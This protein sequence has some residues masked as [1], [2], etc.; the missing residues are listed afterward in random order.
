MSS[1][2]SYV[3]LS[4][5]GKFKEFS[6]EVEES[7]L[8][9]GL[10]AAYAFGAQGDYGLPRRFAPRN[11]TLFGTSSADF[12]RAFVRPALRSPA[13][14]TTIWRTMCQ[15]YCRGGHVRPV[16]LQSKIT[17]PQAITH[18]F[19]RKIRKWNIWGRVADSRPLQGDLILQ[20]QMYGFIDR[21]RCPP[22]FTAGIDAIIMIRNE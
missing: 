14:Q 3:I 6:C 8:F 16:I 5:A 7:V 22:G 13:R 1:R 21:M 10:W 9:C 18:I 19:L 20:P 12:G 15:L 11:D 4:E 2:N 17:S